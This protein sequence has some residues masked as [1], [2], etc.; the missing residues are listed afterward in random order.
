MRAARNATRL[1]RRKRKN[2][3]NNDLASP[4]V[5]LSAADLAARYRVHR[6]TI[7][8]WRAQGRIPE[9]ERLPSGLV[10]WRLRAIEDAEQ[11]NAT[12]VPRARPQPHATRQAQ[13]A[14][15]P[16]T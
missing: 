13:S 12:Y 10:R 4:S 15:I 16:R 5:Y 1:H 3:R 9:P 14:L 2:R 11:N 7:W 6:I 8:K